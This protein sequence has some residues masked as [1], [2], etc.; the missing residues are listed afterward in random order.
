MGGE[1]G[2]F[3]AGT[4]HE[5]DACRRILL[6]PVVLQLQDVSKNEHRLVADKESSAAEILFLTI[7]VPRQWGQA[8]DMR[9]DIFG[10]TDGTRVVVLI[11]C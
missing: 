6:L 8:H 1:R 7:I 4:H 11:S 10:R 5:E 2:Y 3:G 9:S